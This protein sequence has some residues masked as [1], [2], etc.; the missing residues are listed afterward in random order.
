MSATSILLVSVS[1]DPAPLAQTEALLA[2]QR[3]RYTVV[4]RV[5]DVLRAMLAD[6]PSIAIIQGGQPQQQIT[7]L[8]RRLRSFNVP[9]LALAEDLT[10]AQEASLL[11]AGASDV[12][13]LPTSPQRLKARV[14]AMQRYAGAQV[15]RPDTIDSDELYVVGDVVIDVGRREVRVGERPVPVT[16]TEFDL[17]VALAR[18]PRKVLTR[19]ELAYQA[20]SG[21]SVGTHALE[22]H[23]SRLRNK[24]VSA[25]GPRL[26]EPIRGIGYRLGA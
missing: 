3:V 23:I 10:D 18:H 16:K 26:F 20:L 14:L 5:E 15:A 7:D 1:A 24:I 22:S 25:Q 8:V 2:A 11:T 19:E 13:G 12:V 6:P 17:L 21:R 9:T 4:H